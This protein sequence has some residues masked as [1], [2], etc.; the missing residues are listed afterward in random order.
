MSD[1]LHHKL[2]P[3]GR[4]ALRRETLPPTVQVMVRTDRALSDEEKSALEKAGYTVDFATGNVSTGHI[5][6]GRLA[7]LADLAFVR[8]IEVSRQIYQES[9]NE[10]E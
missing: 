2:D 8:R 10:E 1:R 7:G 9:S 6:K 3:R 5:D 4:S